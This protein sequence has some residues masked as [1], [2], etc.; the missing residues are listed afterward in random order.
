MTA[1]RAIFVIARLVAGLGLA[2]LADP[3]TLPGV[4]AVRLTIADSLCFLLL[5]VIEGSDFY[6]KRLKW[7]PGF[8]RWEGLNMIK[9]PPG[10]G[11]LGALDPELLVPNPEV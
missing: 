4:L 6:Y 5:R 10:F 7:E 11:Y 2:L 9:A 3:A 1:W 8:N